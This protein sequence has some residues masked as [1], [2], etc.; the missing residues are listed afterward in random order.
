MYPNENLAIR[1]GCLFL[2]KGVVIFLKSTLI[3]NRKRAP[4]SKT[5]FVKGSIE[6]K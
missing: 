3:E 6:N 4:L 2:I 1:F 5:R